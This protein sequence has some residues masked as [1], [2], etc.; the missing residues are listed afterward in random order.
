MHRSHRHLRHPAA[1]RGEQPPLP[2][3]NPFVV[4]GV[5]VSWAR[6][7]WQLSGGGGGC[8]CSPPRAPRPQALAPPAKP[9]G[10]CAACDLHARGAARA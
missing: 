7:V 1:S 5:L 3:G 8:C 4:Q 10:A 9:A 6:H 2:L